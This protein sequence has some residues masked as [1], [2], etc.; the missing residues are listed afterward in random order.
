[1]DDR[2]HLADDVSTGAAVVS[3][4]EGREPGRADHAALCACVFNPPGDHGM[5][6]VA[7]LAGRRTVKRAGSQVHGGAPPDLFDDPLDD[8]TLLIH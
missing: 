8:Y 2:E 6:C 5:G 1:M 4:G 7:G 3:P